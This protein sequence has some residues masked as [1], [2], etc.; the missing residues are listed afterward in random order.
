MMRQGQ[1]APGGVGRVHV[2][3]SSKLRRVMT[4]RAKVILLETI[5]AA[6]I[7]PDKILVESSN[8]VAPPFDARFHSDVA[9]GTIVT[10]L[11]IKIIKRRQKKAIGTCRIMSSKKGEKCVMLTPGQ[12]HH[13]IF[14]IIQ[15][16]TNIC[17]VFVPFSLFVNSNAE[18]FLFV[19]LNSIDN[20]PLFHHDTSVRKLRDHMLIIISAPIL[21]MYTGRPHQ[22]SA[23]NL[24]SQ[25]APAGMLERLSQ[26]QYSLTSGEKRVSIRTE[27]TII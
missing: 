16:Q 13:C 15:H 3:R 11:G 27:I 26:N 17:R 8:L 10:T 1:C 14:K 7:S 4:I 18:N 25:T 9:S 24:L 21:H 22:K 12:H 2:E 20:T 23:R 5:H 19:I 6:V